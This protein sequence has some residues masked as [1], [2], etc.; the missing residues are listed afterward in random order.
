MHAGAT[1]LVGSRLASKLAA[2]GNR[3]RVITR[4]ANSARGKLPLPGLE[5]YSLAQVQAAVTGA[6]AVINLAGEP[7]GTRWTAE[8]KRAIKTSRLDVTNRVAVRMRPCCC[9]VHACARMPRMPSSTARA[10]FSKALWLL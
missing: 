3:V 4:D 1:G 2:S 9:L 8:I 6:D 10:Y 5:F 7:I